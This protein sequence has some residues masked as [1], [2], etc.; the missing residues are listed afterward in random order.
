M[1]AD[2]QA[3][4]AVANKDT[5]SSGTKQIHMKYHFTCEAVIDN[6]G[7]IHLRTDDMTA[8]IITNSLAKDPFTSQAQCMGLTY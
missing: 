2:N 6:T 1:Y 3:S 7:L 8:D 4:V 5:S